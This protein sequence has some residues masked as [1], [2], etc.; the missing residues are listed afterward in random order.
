M[1]QWRPIK[2]HP[3]LSVSN[4]GNVKNN[5]TNEMLRLHDHNNYRRIAFKEN[6]KLYRIYVHRLVAEAFIPNP[7]NYPVVNHKDEN[8]SNNNVNNL[9]W[10]TQSYNIKYGTSVDRMLKNRTG[11]MKPKGVYV[12]NKFFRSITL[13]SDFI[14]CTRNTLRK[15]LNNSISNYNGYNI[16][17]AV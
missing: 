7:N 12:D 2:E 3:H 16:K 13:A 11:K 4:K 14:G 1:E 10:C 6:K 5:E 8:P 15:K 9:E 17:W